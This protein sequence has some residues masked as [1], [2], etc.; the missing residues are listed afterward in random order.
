M[1]APITAK[2]TDSTSKYPSRP[3]TYN[4][5]LRTMSKERLILYINT[6]LD[7]MDERQL[8][9]VLNFIKGFSY[10]TPEN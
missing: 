4:D 10:D 7:F 2:N 3:L 1:S 6:R 5:L 9:L 8:R